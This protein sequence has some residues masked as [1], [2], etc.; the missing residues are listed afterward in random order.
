MIDGD[1]ILRFILEELDDELGRPGAAR[2]DSVLLGSGAALGSLAL[3]GL[4]TRVEDHCLD[5]GIDFSWASDMA[6]SEKRSNY[7]TPADMAAYIAGLAEERGGCGDDGP[8][9]AAD[10]G[11][12]GERAPAAAAGEM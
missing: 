8:G 9:R 6:M 10:R 11:R 2:P 5:N 4:L 1:D 7:R 3:V 12:W